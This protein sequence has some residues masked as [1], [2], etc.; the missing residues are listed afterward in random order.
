MIIASINSFIAIESLLKDFQ[1]FLTTVGRLQSANDINRN[2]EITIQSAEIL[3]EFQTQSGPTQIQ[4]AKTKSVQSIVTQTFNIHTIRASATQLTESVFPD[5]IT[6]A[7]G[8]V[9]YFRF[10]KSVYVFYTSSISSK[11]RKKWKH[12]NVFFETCSA[13]LLRKRFKKILVF[14]VLSENLF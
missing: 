11:K 8:W 9:H 12:E 14:I 4:P 1:S 6:D 7:N 10:S 5:K 3:I 2:K 13:S